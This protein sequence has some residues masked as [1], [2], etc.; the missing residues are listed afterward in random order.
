[1]LVC[2]RLFHAAT[3]ALMLHLIVRLA[4]PESEGAVTVLP[5]M[6]VPVQMSQV[7]RS[8]NYL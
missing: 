3:I 4:P 1:M 5:R 2:K 7:K 6:E 8:T